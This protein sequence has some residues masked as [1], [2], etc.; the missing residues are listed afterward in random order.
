MESKLER[1]NDDFF[2]ILI[3]ILVL[4]FNIGLFTLIAFITG[5]SIAIMHLIALFIVV[6]C[7]MVISQIK[8]YNVDT[9]KQ[10]GTK[11]K[12]FIID[13]SIDSQIPESFISERSYYVYIRYNK[14]I[15]RMRV[16]KNLAYRI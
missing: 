10:N 5:I 4:V 2:I 11:H 15:N 9:I 13:T 14:K 12:A 8:P 16:K 6:I 1:I 3:W 7:A